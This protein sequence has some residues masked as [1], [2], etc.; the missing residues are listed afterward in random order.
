[1]QKKKLKLKLKKKPVN[2]KPLGMNDKIPIGKFKNCR[3]CF[4]M[5]Q[6]PLELQEAIRRKFLFVTKDVETV[7]EKQISTFIRRYL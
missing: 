2:W 3:V 5:Q 6:Y 4:I 7:L 1:M